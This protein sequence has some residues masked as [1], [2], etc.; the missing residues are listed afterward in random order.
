VLG[1]E[2]LV[3]GVVAI[4]SESSTFAKSAVIE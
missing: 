2:P 1:D 4:D 3:L